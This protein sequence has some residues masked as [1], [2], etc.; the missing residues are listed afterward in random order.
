MFGGHLD[1]H[2]LTTSSDMF[3][4]LFRYTRDYGLRLLLAGIARRLHV[5]NSEMREIWD[6]SDE[7][8][9]DFP[10]IH[11]IDATTM[12]RMLRVMNRMDAQQ[13]FNGRP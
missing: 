4:R 9:M 6:M 5:Q 12:D 1:V 2:R 3:G 11:E 7:N 8:A 13:A 10:A